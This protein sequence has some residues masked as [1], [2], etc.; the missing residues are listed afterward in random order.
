VKRFFSLLSLFFIIGCAQ[1]SS[2]DKARS[3]FRQ[4]QIDQAIETL[5]NATQEGEM[6]PSSVAYLGTLMSIKGNHDLALQYY[7]KAAELDPQS[8]EYLMNVAI[9][10]ESIDHPDTYREWLEKVLQLDRENNRALSRLKAIAE[11]EK[12]YQKQTEK[13]EKSL[14]PREETFEEYFRVAKI[15]YNLHKWDLA[16]KYFLK[17]EQMNP[18]SYEINAFMGR[19]AYRKSDMEGA[20]DRWFVATE[21][22]PSKLEAQVEVGRLYAA[23]S[24]YVDAARSWEK[25]SKL[26]SPGKP[27][28]QEAQ[29][30]LHYLHPFLSEKTGEPKLSF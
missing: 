22:S 30:Y 4:G 18:R 5:Q 9:T 3:L 17:A 24:R 28:Y 10:Y 8:V 11:E 19:L 1:T 20:L 12:R 6:D 7:K 25:V 13:L 27:E 23:L 21:I 2:I 14:A 16:E 15:F 26:S 29:Y